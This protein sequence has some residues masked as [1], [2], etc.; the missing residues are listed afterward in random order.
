[1]TSGIISSGSIPIPL[2]PISSEVAV[3]RDAKDNFLLAWCQDGAANF[4]LTGDQDLLVLKQFRQTRI[5]SWAMAGTEPGLLL[6]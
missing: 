6:S 5:I 4:L 2:T 3:C 1:M